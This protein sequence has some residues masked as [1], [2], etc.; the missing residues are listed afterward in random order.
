MDTAQG[1]YPVYNGDKQAIP[2]PRPPRSIYISLSLSLSLGLSQCQTYAQ[3]HA[4]THT[5]THARHAG[6]TVEN[7]PSPRSLRTTYC[8]RMG[9]CFQTLQGS[10]V[11]SPAHVQHPMGVTERYTQLRQHGAQTRQRHVTPVSRSVT[12]ASLRAAQQSVAVTPA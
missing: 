4:H 7:A 3:T 10:S 12:P 1:T 8:L 9:W 6:F 2:P 11:R 5:H